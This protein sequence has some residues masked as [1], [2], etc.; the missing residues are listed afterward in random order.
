VR[1]PF[2]FFLISLCTFLSA[3]VS[4]SVSEDGRD[5]GIQQVSHL[6]DAPGSLD[7][8]VASVVT[9]VTKV[10]DRS[11]TLRLVRCIFH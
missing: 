1:F 9:E 6:N 4:V 8:L 7:S 3:K 11:L 2:S 5:T 10:R